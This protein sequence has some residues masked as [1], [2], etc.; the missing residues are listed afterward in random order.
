MQR[1][2]VPLELDKEE[3]NRKASADCFQ[4]VVRCWCRACK[5]DK[6]EN[7]MFAGIIHPDGIGRGICIKCHVEGKDVERWKRFDKESAP[8]EKGQQ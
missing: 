6:N 5:Q 3:I 7:E 1:L 2:R 4:R 8:N